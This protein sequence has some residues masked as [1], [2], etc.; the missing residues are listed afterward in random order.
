MENQYLNSIFTKLVEIKEKAYAPYSNFKV[1]ALCRVG[2]EWFYGVNIE[3]SS[4]PAG[5]CAERSAICAAISKGHKR[6]DEIYIAT[7]SNEIG[8]PCGLCRQF[9]SDFMPND[10]QKVIVFNNKGNYKIY[11][12]KD[13]L[14]DR[15]SN[16]QLTN[17]E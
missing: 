15:F 7:D 3:N 11:N 14:L 17:K 4:Y 9:M 10:T 1:G 2:E 6:I 13:L 8:T 16:K 5:N 12:I